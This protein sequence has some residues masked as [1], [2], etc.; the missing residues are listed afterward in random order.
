MNHKSPSGQVSRRELIKRAGVLGAGVAGAPL[1]AACTDDE[2]G[3]AGAV[4]ERETGRKV[5]FVT[6]DNNPFFVPVI[7]GFEAFGALRGWETQFVG[8]PQQDVPATVEMQVNA[9]ASNP[10]A[11]AFTRVDTTSFDDNIQRARD[12]GIFVILYNTA[13]DGYE[14]L[15][16]AFV[17]QEFVAAGRINGAQAAQHAHE[18]TGREE[19]LIVMGTIAPGHSALEQRMQGTTQGVE[20]YNADNGTGFTTETLETSTDQAEAISR[21][22]A[23]YQRDGDRIVGWA[24]ADFGHWFTGI[25]VE[26]RGLEGSMANG[27]FDLVPGVLDAI[28][29]DTAQWSIGQN[30]YAQGWVTSTLIDMALEADFPPFDYDTGAEVVDSANVDEVTEREAK[31]A[32]S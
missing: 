6:H 4:E 23:K 9:I 5:T 32:E 8:P 3:E 20:E 28:K 24:H 10:D 27:G 1:L 29:N 25:W 11:V 30:P 19:G 2:P 18:I 21:V 22:D 26:D 7:K 17:G 13:S 16:V 12:Q 15:G 14:D 31:F